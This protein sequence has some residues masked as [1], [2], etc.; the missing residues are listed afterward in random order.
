MVLLF[1]L[2]FITNGK[3]MKA[4]QPKPDLQLKIIQNGRFHLLLILVAEGSWQL[5]ASEHSWENE[6]HPAALQST[7]AFCCR[8]LH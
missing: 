3:K 5:K 4:S 6:Q 2:V 8:D 1:S 7:L